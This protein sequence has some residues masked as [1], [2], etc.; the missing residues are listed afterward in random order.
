MNWANMFRILDIQNL[1]KKIS[2][3]N[4]KANFNM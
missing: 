3:K 1:N 4:L 2:V